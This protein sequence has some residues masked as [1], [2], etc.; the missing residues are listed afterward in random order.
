MNDGS[1]PADAPVRGLKEK[2]SVAALRN[3]SEA[4]KTTCPASASAPAREKT[5]K[6]MGKFSSVRRIIGASSGPDLRLFFDPP[7]LSPKAR[8]QRPSRSKKRIYDEAER[9]PRGLSARLP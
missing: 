9:H 3:P 5:R 6:W 4:V 8:Q 2:T 1:C 7:G